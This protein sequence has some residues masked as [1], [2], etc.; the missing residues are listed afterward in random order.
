MRADIRNGG[1]G[2]ACW[3]DEAI[4]SF[5]AGVSERERELGQRN[6]DLVVIPGTISCFGCETQEYGYGTKCT[7]QIVKTTYAVADEIKPRA[8]DAA[9]WHR[10]IPG[11]VTIKPDSA[12]PAEAPAVSPANEHA[13][14]PASP[15]PA[16]PTAR[17]GRRGLFGRSG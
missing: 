8:A 13:A 9:G 15:S 4:S 6:P 3:N 17:T 14:R 5:V 11:L 7:A 1:D 16:A 12:A 2:V 10:E